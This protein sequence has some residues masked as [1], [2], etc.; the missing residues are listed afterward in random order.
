MSATKAYNQDIDIIIYISSG[1]GTSDIRLVGGASESEGR[2]EILHDGQWGTVCDD[3]WDDLDAIVVC[4]QLGY[5][6]GEANGL[7]YFGAGRS[8]I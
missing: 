3:N 2:V 7:A 5:S 1:S 6:H 4:Q 8:T